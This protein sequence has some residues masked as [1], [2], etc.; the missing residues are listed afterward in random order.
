[1]SN[2]LHQA[3]VKL[4]KQ[5]GRHADVVMDVYL[6]GSINEGQHD[7]KVVEKLKKSGILWRPEPDQDLRLK[8]SVRAL[9][10]EALSDERNRQIDAN[11]GSALATIKTLADHYKEARANSDYSA[12]EAYLA[13]L[14]EHV[15]SFTD[16]LRYSVRVLWGRIN[17]EF[18]YVG[19]ISAKIRENELAQSQVTELLN[20]L[21]MFQFSELGEIAGDIR[22]LRKLLITNMQE[23]LSQCTQELSVVQARL[24]EL[25]GRFRQIQGRTRLLKG[26][27][28]HNDLHPDY[29]VNDHVSHNNIAPLFN[30]SE[31]LL[32]AAHVDVQN[33]QH[34]LDLLDIVAQVKAIN[35][36]DK[37]LNTRETE[38]AFSLDDTQE[39]AIPDNPLKQAVD[40]YFCAIIDSGQAQ[41]ALEYLAQ[42]QLPWD[43]ES[44]IYQVIGGYEGLPEEHKR[45]FELEPLGEPDP[46]YSGNYIIHDV[47]LWLA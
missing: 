16:S 18:G 35:H 22:Q 17:N 25:L 1:M 10:E 19:S 26:W 40:E 33:P 39:F 3:G 34:E 42:K 43:S 20:G 6:S 7:D 47:E 46:I 27:L 4:L 8:R 11:V 23:T 41:S 21:D 36:T 24:F 31:P 44:W 45:F 37:P 13:D 14:N 2:N 29:V 30:C 5:L 15:Y 28:L 38:V 32:A 9:L 12:S